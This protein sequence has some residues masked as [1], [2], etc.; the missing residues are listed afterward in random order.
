MH[1]ATRILLLLTA[2]L[3]SSSLPPKVEGK[4]YRVA[5]ASEVKSASNIAR[6][7]DTVILAN[8]TWEGVCLT[9]DECKGTRERPIT[10][11]AETEGQVV[12]TG[13]SQFR[14]SGQHV[15][16]AGF[17]FRDVIGPSESCNFV[18]TVSDSPSIFASRTAL[19]PNNRLGS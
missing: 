19:S 9:F 5:S 13:N 3:W 18:P 12:F 14:F 2:V 6:A 8:G 17:V 1:V 15:I 16:V 7:G 4:E 11:R 10:I